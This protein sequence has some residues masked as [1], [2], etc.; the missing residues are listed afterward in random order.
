[1]K[2]ISALILALMFGAILATSVAAAEVAKQ[3][4]GML[5]S[6]KSGT[7]EILKLAEGHMQV[8]WHELGVFVQVPEDSPLVN[9]S[10]NAMGTL[11]AIDGKFQ[12][13]G[14]IVITCQN[15]DKIFGR[16]KDVEGVRGVGPSKGYAEFTGGTGSC[17]GI[18]G[19]VELLQN[20]KVPSSA[21]GTYQGI[22]RGKLT[23]KLP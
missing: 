7:Y 5:R 23:W 16:I 3:G 20:P 18:E 8:N 17:E 21:K 22:G 11:Y 19:G 4:S 12:S 15:G 1:M 14:A 9:A 10:F 2:R 6:G 13:N